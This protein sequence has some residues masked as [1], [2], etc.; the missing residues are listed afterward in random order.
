[1]WYWLPVAAWM[2]MIF[3]A[4]TDIGSAAHSSRIIQPVLHFLFP[5]LS[6]EAIDLVVTIVRKGCHLT[7]YAILAFLVR[8]ARR[9]HLPPEN[10]GWHWSEAAEA[11]WVTVFYAATDELH[12]TFVPSREGCLRDVF[13]DS[14]GAV[15]GMLILWVFGRVRKWW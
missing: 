5:N 11:V 8:R 10:R 12:Q 2:F 15:A 3:G 14:S 7:E 6:A 4:S 9:S 13:I 1:V